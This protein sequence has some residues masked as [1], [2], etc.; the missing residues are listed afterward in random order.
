MKTI[1]LSEDANTPQDQG[2]MLYV[3]QSLQ[4][5][6]VA[7]KVTGQAVYTDDIDLPGLTEGRI[8]H[9]PHA[10]ARVKSID[11]SKAEALPGV[12]AVLTHKDA[13]EERFS[14]STMAE[15]LPSFAYDGERQDQRILTD[16][17][18]YR[19]DCVA[20]VVA[21]DIYIAEQ[22]LDLIEVEYELL[23]PIFDP[24]EA[25]KPGAVAVHD[26]VKNNVAFEMDH[27]FNVGDT[28]KAFEEA[29]VVVEFSGVNSRQKHLHMET[30]SAIAHFDDNGRV[31][32][33]SPSQGPHLGKKHLSERVFTDLEDGDIRWISPAIGGGFGARLAL[34]LE[35]MAVLLAKATKRPVRVT[36]TRE[37]DFNGYSSRTDQHQTVRLAAMKDGTVV[38]IEQHVISDAGAYLSHSATTSLVNMQKSL[39]LFRCDNVFGHVKVVYTNTPVTAGYRGYGNA[40]GAFIFQQATDILA[41]KLGMSPIE[42]RSKNIRKEGEQSFFLPCKLE[43]TRLQECI[44]EGAKAFGWDEK[45]KGW[46]RD[47]SEGRFRRGVG[48]S[49][50]N[51]ASGAGG[52][53]LE[54]SSAIMKVQ[55]DGSANLVIS[56]C[57]MGQGILGAL[58]QVAAELSGVPYEKIRVVTGDTDVTLFD[59]GSHASRSMFVVGNAV[60][61]CARKINEIIRERAIPHF[62]KR[63][64]KV[65]KDDL[66]VRGGEIFPEDRPDQAI[67]VGEVAH[68]EIYN[69]SEAGSQISAPGAY[70][71][72][73][74]HPNHQAAFAE[75]EVDTETGHVSV[76]KYLAAHDIGRTI[77]PLLVESQMDGSAVQGLGFALKEDFVLDQKTGEVLNDTLLTYTVPTV[78]DVPEME[79]LMIEDPYE[80]GPLGA[81]G[82]GEAGVVNPAAA[83]A[84]AIY[85]AI[86]VRVHSLPASPEKVLA[87]LQTD[88]QEMPSGASHVSGQ[89]L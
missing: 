67:P 32:V 5:P 82:V 9:C 65:D 31:T 73:S 58:A 57:E 75:V 48:M 17:C 61:N 60:A 18:R 16:I 19:G 6:D 42:L 25:M 45:F 87:M 44:D 8:L 81:K 69:F 15:A 88:G 56:P 38:G 14:R 35:P 41:E 66:I 26:D 89:R 47:R 7:Q 50:L 52:F 70:L 59:I 20:A 21:E 84:N 55:A 63:Q 13:P 74:H 83:V 33:I 77:N 23:D 53:L 28:K 78:M 76:V 22:A 54:H 36:S 51:H 24:F 80:K 1:H 39:G 43:H 85:D 49:I 10:F 11:T 12:L 29:D 27:P 72:T 86:G 79:A 30:D 3:G 64:I 40:E 2:G 71:S 34:G 46:D 68:D 4:K 37:E 62:E